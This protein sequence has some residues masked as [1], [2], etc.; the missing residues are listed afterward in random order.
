M[1]DFG[2]GIPDEE[3]SQLFQSFFRAEN[4]INIEGT[5]LGLVILKQFVELHSGTVS[6]ESQEGR[7]TTVTVNIPYRAKD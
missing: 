3:K 7:G 5:G 4:T 2:I 1:K 6:I